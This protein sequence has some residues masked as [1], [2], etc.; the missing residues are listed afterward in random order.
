MVSGS[1]S[2]TLGRLYAWEKK[3]FHEV[4]AGQQTRKTYKHKY[5]QLQQKNVEEDDLCPSKASTKVSDLYHQ[6]L[7]AL[8]RAES[9]SKQIEKLRDEELQPQL[10]ELLHGLTKSWKSMSETHEIQRKI[11]QE[12]NSFSCPEHQRFCVESHRLA[13]LQLEAVIQDW[14]S[15]FSEYISA[16]K[17]YVKSLHGWLSKFIDAEVE[18]HYNRNLSLPP[19]RFNGPALIITCQHWSTSLERLP[20]ISVKYAMRNLGKEIQALWVQQG[21]EQQQKRKVDSLDKDLDRKILAFGKAEDK[22]VMS[23]Y[24]TYHNVE[25]PESL[26]M[27][28]EQLEMFRKKVETEREKYHSS[29]QETERITMQRLRMGFASVFESLADF[30]RASAKAYADIVTFSQNAKV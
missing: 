13:T 12:I 6:M 29:V 20:D 16:Q 18:Y 10:L 19:S 30:S 2:F 22:A 11:M 21:V 1:H 26:G 23:K 28:K 27:K 14:N 3:L 15:C 4:K 17:A 24:T 5:S 9:I 8:Q 25:Q 7:V